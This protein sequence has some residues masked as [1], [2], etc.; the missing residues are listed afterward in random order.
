MNGL[1]QAGGLSGVLVAGWQADKLGRCKAIL[2]S[3]FITIIGSALQAGSVHIGMFL[4]ARFITGFGVGGLVM[5]IP[6]WQSEVAPP[7]SRGLLVGLHG[8][9]I[10]IGYNL[11]NWIGYGFFFVNASGAQW[12]I[13]LAIQIIPAL[14]LGC[15]ILSIPESPRWLVE[16]N[17]SETAKTILERIHKDPRNPDN[18]FARREFQ[19]IETQLVFEKT[20]PSSWKSLFTVP[21][22]RKRVWIGMLTMFAG[23]FTG[24]LVVA[25]YG[26]SIYASLG[27][28][29]SQRLLISCGWIT[30]GLF[31][32]V[33]NAFLLDRVGRRWLLTIGLG[34]C[35]VALLGEIIMVALFQGTKNNA[36]NSA[37][38]FFLFL[39]LAFYGSCIDAS[40]YVFAAEIW[41]TH[42]RAKGFAVSVSGLFIGSLIL[43]VAAP[44]GFQNLGWKFY[45]VMLVV[46]VVN[47][48]IVAVFFP[49]T[50]GL[51]LEEIAALFGDDMV[52]DWPH[53][54]VVHGLDETSETS[55]PNGDIEKGE[56]KGRVML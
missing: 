10:L 22:Y 44:T 5:L 4:A 16:N 21:Q 26:P 33:I 55:A 39:H 43:L 12:R 20:L 31:A 7:F 17:R 28:G 23:Q 19:Q 25:N 37:A 42:L 47:T 1:F 53:A 6:L 38:V 40:T 9:S 32:N 15:G 11:S 3:T 36:G 50:K 29:P 30:E 54:T 8:V 24:T 35:A 41:P 56:A 49:E 51:T 14:V 52:T 34:G 27:Y 2:I 18:D 45:L 48:I 13:P 46:T